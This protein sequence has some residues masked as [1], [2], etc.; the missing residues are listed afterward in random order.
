MEEYHECWLYYAIIDT[1][2]IV[3]FNQE[4]DIVYDVLYNMIRRDFFFE[5][6][7]KHK[8]GADYDWFCRIIYT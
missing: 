7:W 5:L 6:S 3:W 2:A 1:V 4:G 8:I